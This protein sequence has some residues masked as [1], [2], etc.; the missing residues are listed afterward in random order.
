MTG[1]GFESYATFPAGDDKN[2]TLQYDDIFSS[3]NAMSDTNFRTL[4]RFAIDRNK[5]NFSYKEIYDLVWKYFST[6]LRL[7]TNGGMKMALFRVTAAS[8]V[9]TTVFFKKLIPKP[10]GVQ[11]RIIDATNTTPMFGMSDYV[12]GA[13]T[14]SFG[15]S[16]YADYDTLQGNML[17]YAQI[18]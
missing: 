4:I 8:V 2:G 9:M 18:T 3:H 14:Y 13:S 1:Y 6:D 7:E 11:L 17:Q 16:T 12:D 5:N 15:F 10:M